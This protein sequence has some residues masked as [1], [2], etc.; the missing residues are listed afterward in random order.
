MNGGVP[1]QLHMGAAAGTVTAQVFPSSKL[2][3][4]ACVEIALSFLE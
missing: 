4:G 3:L 2:I 1:R